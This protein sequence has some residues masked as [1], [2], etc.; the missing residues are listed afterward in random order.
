[1][2]SY[3]STISPLMMLNIIMAKIQKNSK[4]EYLSNN[5]SIS[6]IMDNTPSMTTG[7]ISSEELPLYTFLS[8]LISG[9][10]QSSTNISRF[11]AILFLVLPQF[12]YAE[13][14]RTVSPNSA[15]VT[16]LTI[17]PSISA[18]TYLNCAEDNRIYF[19]IANAGE[20]LY[21][22]FQ[23]RSYGGTANPATLNNMYIKIFR[24]DGTLAT[25]PTLLAN[26]GNGFINN[27]TEAYNGPNIAGT[28]PTGY[29]PLTFTPT[30]TGEY[31]V[32]IYRS[33]DGGATQATATTW[34]IAPYFDMTV[35]TPAGVRK[36]GRVHSDKWGF[37]AIDATFVP[38]SL[39]SAEPTTWAYT[40]DQTVL[41]VDFQVGF[42]PIAFNVAVNSYGVANTGNFLADRK[43]INSTVA[44]TLSNGYKVFINV[45]DA[46]AYPVAPIPTNPSFAS[47]ALI[48]CPGGSAQIRYYLPE[49]GDVRFL[50]DLNGTAGYQSGT[51]DRIIEVFGQSTGLNI[52]TWD[53]LNGLGV[54]VTNGTPLN[55]T[56][57]YMKGRFN[58]PLYDAEINSNGLFP[59]C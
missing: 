25:G 15:N 9:F 50:F 24:P 43:S 23:W 44:P 37:A 8:N 29:T 18:G 59:F 10:S 1:M 32:E 26:S 38:S 48:G 14:T 58:V 46:L 17:M 57:T 40:T 12:L 5:S 6:H 20:N 39:A 28:A 54:A 19:N 42:K 53:G 22:G 11:A 47:P 35:A 13:G 49:A 41:K 56:L 4:K 21:Y 16:A 7:D 45:P 2:K 51:S 33:T 27:Y 36:D 55:I 34:S 31:W 3:K 30:V 52:Y